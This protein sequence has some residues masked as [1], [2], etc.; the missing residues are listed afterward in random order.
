MYF[1]SYSQN[2]YFRFPFV[3]SCQ[4]YLFSEN[5]LLYCVLGDSRLT[6]VS[7]SKRATAWNL[8]PLSMS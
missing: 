6:V 8:P 7:M 1:F 5:H 2:T 3:K 4:E